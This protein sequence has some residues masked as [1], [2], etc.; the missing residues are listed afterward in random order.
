MNDLP[1]YAQKKK[2][3]DVTMQNTAVYRHSFVHISNTL[4][5]LN[6]NDTHYIQ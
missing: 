2:T 4:L 5:S 3:P 1:K 6:E